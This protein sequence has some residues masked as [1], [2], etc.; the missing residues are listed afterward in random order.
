MPYAFK[1]SPPFEPLS[2][3]PVIPTLYIQTV[4]AADS[5]KWSTDKEFTDY[6]MRRS[7][8]SVEKYVEIDDPYL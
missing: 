3:N 4:V 8:C 2:E 7:N 6:L 1:V 5:R